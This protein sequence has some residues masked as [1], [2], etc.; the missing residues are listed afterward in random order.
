MSEP[1]IVHCHIP[2]T[3]GSALN[4]GFLTAMHGEAR[5]YQMYG[6]VFEAASRLPRHQVARGMRSYVAVGHV[7]FGYFDEIYPEAIYLSIFREPVARFLSF[8]NSVLNN[9]EHTVRGSLCRSVLKN[10]ADDPEPL[11]MAVLGEPRLADMYRNVQVRLAGGSPLLGGR[12]TTSDHLDAALRNIAQAR[13]ITST[14]EDLPTMFAHLRHRFDHVRAT[15]PAQNVVPKPS[16]RTISVDAI[17][18]KILDRVR[19][20]NDL[21]I[22][23]YNQL[24]ERRVSNFCEAA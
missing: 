3:G 13:Y 15:D 1:F 24:A 2:K 17:R 11:I 8:L 5:V 18:P 12:S 7:P 4:R 9:P 19:A 21:D 14:L 22:R 6:D 10:G 20:T 16:A 23:L